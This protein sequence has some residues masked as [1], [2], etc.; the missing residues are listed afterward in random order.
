MTTKKRKKRVDFSFDDLMEALKKTKNIDEMRW[1]LRDKNGNI[2]LRSTVE[3][4]VIDMRMFFCYRHR[5]NVGVKLKPTAD[6][7]LTY[8][9]GTVYY[10]EEGV[11]IPNSVITNAGYKKADRLKLVISDND[12]IIADVITTD[13]TIKKVKES[14]FKQGFIAGY[15]CRKNS[16]YG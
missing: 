13:I 1:L 8:R 2:P 12:V 10:M 9:P 11:F 5:S 4:R 16:V 3:N 7:T 14:T 6:Y 15:I